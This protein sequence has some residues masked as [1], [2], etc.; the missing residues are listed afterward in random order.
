MVMIS[1]SQRVSTVP[2]KVPSSILGS[3]LNAG[4]GCVIF[5]RRKGLV[6]IR[7]DSMDVEA[8]SGGEERQANVYPTSSIV[9]NAFDRMAG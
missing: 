8:A 2:E 5:G 6:A 3:T 7:V 4:V 1:R 9:Q